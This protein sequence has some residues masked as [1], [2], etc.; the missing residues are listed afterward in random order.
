MKRRA[1]LRP[2]RTELGARASS[3]GVSGDGGLRAPAS[4]EGAGA[5]W[6][7]G[8]EVLTAPAGQEAG[9]GWGAGVRRPGSRVLP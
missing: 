9:R 4:G 8:T 2:R 6:T 5:G 3:F 7:A 1:K